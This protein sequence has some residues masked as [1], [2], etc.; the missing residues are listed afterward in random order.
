[1]SKL[2]DLRNPQLLKTGLFPGIP[3]QAVPLW[4]DG[5]NVYFDEFG[6]KSMPGWSFQHQ[7]TIEAAAQ[8]GGL[9]Q[10]QD[11]NF[12]RIAYGTEENLYFF[13]PGVGATHLRTG[14]NGNR[15]SIIPFGT[16]FL[17]S[18]GVDPVQIWKNSGLATDLA[19]TNF[20]SAEILLQRGP[21]ILAVNTS[22]GGNWVQWS[23]IDDPE[24]W[25]PTP[26]NAAGD[27]PIREITGDI[28]AAVPLGTN[29]MLYGHDV[30]VLLQYLGAPLYF[31]SRPA[32]NGIGAVGKYSVASVGNSNYGFGEGGFFRTDGVNFQ[33]ID[34]PVKGW[35]AE[36]LNQGAKREIRAYHDEVE[37]TV[38]WSIP[39]GGSVVPNAGLSYNYKQ[40]AWS[41]HDHGWEA[42]DERQLFGYPIGARGDSIYFI[43]DGNNADTA[44]INRRIQ[45]KP[46]N[47]DAP[48]LFKYFDVVRVLAQ[49]NAGLRVRVGF[50]D[51][52]DAP[53][54]WED[55]AN[56]EEKLYGFVRS[57]VYIVFEFSSV[58]LDADWLVNG[59]EAYGWPDGDNI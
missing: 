51:E 4:A 12:I 58:D 15:W 40:N 22:N 54:E 55:Y 9:A 45:T 57:A 11:G 17:F 42:A 48:D 50:L 7:N 20:T 1:M 10:G 23:H 8:I 25:I 47:G 41:V 59:F 14:F 43:G 37:T 36:N 28:L 46:I 35:I 30:A 5:E 49:R 19:G 18:N 44:P 21:H 52:I 26:T 32:I 27:L 38:R 2:I 16:W 39:T 53:I 31:G 24:Q 56:W 29:F 3:A 34:E 33:Y 13:E 6:V